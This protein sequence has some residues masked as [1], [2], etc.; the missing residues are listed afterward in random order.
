MLKG[1]ETCL[2][3]TILGQK[4]AGGWLRKPFGLIRSVFGFGKKRLITLQALHVVG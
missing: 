1:A 3:V 4:G 2:T